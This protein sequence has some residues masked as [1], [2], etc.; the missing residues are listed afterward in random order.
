MRT[1][2]PLKALVTLLLA[3]ALPIAGCS[4]GPSTKE[5]VCTSFDHLREKAVG[6]NGLWDNAVFHKAGELSGL[7][8]RYE[9]TDLSADAAALK[10][11]A[12]S[13]STTVFALE[14]ATTSISR[15]CGHDFVVGN[16]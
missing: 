10:K 7:A 12:D 8:G 11:I 4:Q 14:K 1:T 6:A 3:A 5:E 16:Y 15:L 13:D 2:A 9:G